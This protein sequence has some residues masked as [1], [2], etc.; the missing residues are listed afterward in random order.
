MTAPRDYQ[1]KAL[2]KIYADLQTTQN[3]LLVG[4]MGC[5][6]TFMAV[7]LISRL[8]HESPD[9]PFLVLMHKKELVEQFFESFTKFTEIPFTEIGLCCAGLGEKII[10]RRITI[11][12]IQTFVN[13]MD[14]YMGA[15]LTIID[16]AHRID[17]NGNTQYKQVIDYLRLQRPNCRILGITAT[18]ARLGHGYIY[19]NRCKPGNI[20]LFDDLSH[21]IKYEE[22]KD[23][24]YLVPLKG[25]I[26]NH[27]HLKQDLAGVSTNG[28]YV[29]DQLGEI[30][31]REIHLETAVEAIEKYCNGYKRIC[32]FCCTIDH[33]VKLHAL[34]GDSATIVHSRLDSLARATNM[35]DW[36]AGR[37]P[38]MVSV[39][40]LTEGFDLPVLDCLVFARPTLS[41]TLYLQAVG[42]V[43]RPYSGKDHGF[44]V[45]LTDNSARF[46]TDLDNVKVSIPK[47][48]EDEDKKERS[49]WKI[50]PECDI[51]V[52]VALRECPDC[53]FEW[54]ETECVVAG[55]LPEMREVVFEQSPPE[56]FDVDDWWAGVHQSKK[57]GNLLGRIDY[58]FNESDYRRS[59]VSMFLCFPD[60]YEGYAVEMSR[61]KWKQISDDRFPDNVEDF[62]QCSRLF[63]PLQVE[64]DMNGKYPDLKRVICDDTPV[65]IE[66]G[67]MFNDTVPF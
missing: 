48:V 32:V 19:G 33:A 17:I 56:I 35:A 24:G 55:A 3:V 51:E 42:R 43:L 21:R 62:K 2:D 5:G 38:I 66:N 13:S 49:M 44:L 22:L 31:S 16:E 61:K 9:M 39:N 65:Y 18:P 52:H 25:V 26:A 11:A 54:P 53:G 30:M 37:K 58:Y 60:F 20:N 46:G 50:C 1:V 40:I 34:L 67:E 45:D 63:T 6:K 36:E 28:D 47:A 15:G 57:N 27:E 64:V 41:S 8:Y 14:G 7:K 59:K 12:S 23:A 4:M 10:S 29:L